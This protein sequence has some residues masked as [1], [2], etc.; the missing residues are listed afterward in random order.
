MAVPGGGGQAIADADAK[1]SLAAAPLEAA[2]RLSDLSLEG[3]RARPPRRAGGG[4]AGYLAGKRAGLGAVVD[5]FGLRPS[6]APPPR[7]GAPPGH[8]PRCQLAVAR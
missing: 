2:A 4:F 3:G 5:A 8:R 6:R 1:H 7:L